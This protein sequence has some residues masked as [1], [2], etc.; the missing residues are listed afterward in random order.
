MRNI[1]YKFLILIWVYFSGLG[2]NLLYAQ[3]Y[4]SKI[5]LVIGNTEYT[6][7]P[8]LKNASNDAFAVAQALSNKGFTVFLVRDVNAQ[9]LRDS[10]TFVSSRA[11]HAE[12]IF[13]YYAGHNEIQNGTPQLIPIN[14]AASPGENPPLAL[15]IPD[16]LE[17]FD[18]PF[19]QKTVVIDACLQDPPAPYDTGLQTLSLPKA[20]GLETLLVFA[21]SFGQAAYDGTG[22]H[23]VFTGAFLDYMVKDTLNLQNTIQSVRNDVIQSSRTN[24]IP[25]SVSTLTRPYILDARGSVIRDFKSQNDL[26][27]SYSSS[28]YASKPLL[29]TISLGINPTGF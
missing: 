22:D 17:Y 3:D 2:Q 6:N 23:S 13:I 1:H 11:A 18:I 5:A 21:T 25:V 4:A 27:Q 10:L 24:Q 15:T 29:D 20:L 14:S 28:G 9:E 7:L 19:A 16:L 12:Q 26:I 8:R